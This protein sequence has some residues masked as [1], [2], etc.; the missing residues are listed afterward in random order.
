MWLFL[1]DD[2][3]AYAKTAA[4]LVEWMERSFEVFHGNSF[5]S[6]QAKCVFFEKKIRWCG[7][8]ISSDGTRFD[9]ICIEGLMDVDPPIN[10][11]E[12]QQFICALQCVKSVNPG[13][14]ELLEPL[15]IFLELL[16]TKVGKRTEWDVA[17]VRLGALACDVKEVNTFSECQKALGNQGTLAH[18]SPALRLNI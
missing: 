18:R 17:G 7:R 16:Y 2:I 15:H 8:I 11:G 3:V 4:E 5:R 9:L 13:F 10:G 1:L 12:L 14:S 6:Y